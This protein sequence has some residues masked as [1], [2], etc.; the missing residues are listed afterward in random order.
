M[1]TRYKQLVDR[2]RHCRS[3]AVIG[4]STDSQAPANAIYTRLQDMGISVHAVNIHPERIRTVP[5]V[6][7]VGDIEGSVD[8]A[9]IC[10]PAAAGRK[11]VDE[12][13]AKGVPLVWF[14]RSI[15]PGSYDADAHA[16][17]TKLGM[18]VIPGGCPMMEFNVDGFRK[19]MRFFVNLG[20]VL[21]A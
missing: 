20:G 18:D 17:A 7:T 8:A 3:V 9:M 15:G 10:T 13:N 2:F 14:H 1:N 12:C 16:H 19:V 6:A 11:V 5:C 4:Y 21:K